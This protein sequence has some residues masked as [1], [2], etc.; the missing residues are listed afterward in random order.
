MEYVFGF[1]ERGGRQIENLKTIG[2]E[3]ELSGQTELTTEYD[4]AV[5]T[6]TFEV[7]EKYNVVT[8][9]E[10]KIYNFYEIRNH[11]KKI[12]YDII[13]EAAEQIKA[14]YRDEL[15]SEVSNIGYA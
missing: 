8:D 10:G 5:I 12:S 4:D 15:V 3:T 6:D 11:I 14:D 2:E 7:V 1:V 13:E 9:Q